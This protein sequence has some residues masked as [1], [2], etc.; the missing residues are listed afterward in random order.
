[1]F[2]DW[3]NSR[4]CAVNCSRTPLALF[5]NPNTHECVIPL[6]CPNTWFADNQTLQCIPQC[7]GNLPFGDPIS[8]QCV[9]DCPDN[10]YG[11]PVKHL[12]VQFCN[13]TTG[14]YADN[15]TGNC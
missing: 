15:Y 11:D 9:S 3:Q 13:L 12:C 4:K 8:L 1:M 10:Y 6:K 7:N 5:G 14:Y 2:G